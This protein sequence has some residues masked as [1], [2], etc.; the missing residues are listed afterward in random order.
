MFLRGSRILSVLSLFV[1]L[2]LAGDASA[3]EQGDRLE[4]RGWEERRAD[5][6]E[7]RRER[8]QRFLRAL[9]DDERAYYEERIDELRRGYDS[10][11][12]LSSEQQEELIRKR[13]AL[14]T[15]L[16][17]RR[18]EAREELRSLPR[19]ERRELL[20]KLRNF[21]ELPE[22]E[23]RQLR[24]RYQMLRERS[25]EER[26]RLR[27]NSRRWNDMSPERR[28]RLLEQRRRLHELSPEERKQLREELRMKR[29]DRQERTR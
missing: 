29:R 4:R 27:E 25:P 12:E 7:F 2:A 22:E 1:A 8:L 26:E 16:W 10:Y 23:Q 15:E 9:P 5:R 20:R 13:R 14:R 21:R 3:Q 18:H 24:E 17:G 28:E 19:E 6:L 11:G